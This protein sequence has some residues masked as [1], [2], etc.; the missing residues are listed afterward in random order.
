MM[1]APSAISISSAFSGERKCSEPSRCERK[2]TPSI[3][4]FAQ[5]A[6]TENLEAA[7]IG[8]NRARPRHEFVQAV[9][10]ADEFMAGTKKQMVGVGKQD[11]H[12]EV[13]EILL[14][15]AFYGSGGAHGHECGSVDYTVRRRQAA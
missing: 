9:H 1:S 8:E 14:R 10:L 11:L 3:C 6:E 12:A 7:G 15:L 2:V 4:D 13:F 5:F